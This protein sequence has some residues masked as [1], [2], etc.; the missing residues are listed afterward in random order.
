MP[1]IQ[2]VDSTYG[3]LT[4]LDVVG[5]P[6]GY[7]T[8]DISTGDLWI[9]SNS[10]EEVDHVDVEAVNGNHPQMRWLRDQGSNA[11][12]KTEGLILYAS[13]AGDNASTGADWSTA[14]E[15]GYNAMARIIDAGGGELHLLDSTVWGG[16][17]T[18]Q[19]CWLRDDGLPVEGFQSVVPV[20]IVH[21]GGRHM[22]FGQPAG[23][24][25]GGKTAAGDRFHP[26]F[27][28]CASGRSPVVIENA[29]PAYS[30]H[31]CN[32][33]GRFGWDYR[34]TAA[35]A[36]DFANITEWDRAAGSAVLTVELPAGLAIT[37]AT[38]TSNVTR[39]TFAAQTF[40][41][42][43]VGQWITV[44]SS[45]GSFSSGP[46]QVT[47][48][49]VGSNPTWLEY[50]DVGANAN[51]NNI[52]TW[53]THGVKRY[54]RIE[55][56][57]TDGEVPSCAYRVTDTTALTITVVD[58]YGYAPRTATVTVADPG[59]Y[60]LQDRTNYAVGLLTL[61][62][63]GGA[64]SPSVGTDQFSPGPTMDFGSTTDGRILFEGGSCTGYVPTVPCTDP[65]RA[66]W[67][68]VDPGSHGAAGLRVRHTDPGGTGIRVYGSKVASWAFRA[69]SV[70][71]DTQIGVSAP[72]QLEVLEGGQYGTIYARDVFT[73]DN[74]PAVPNVRLDAAG[75]QITVFDC[76]LVE[77]TGNVS[78]GPWG[79]RNVSP[80]VAG[81]NCFWAG[82]AAADIPHARR[83]GTLLTPRYRNFVQNDSS[84]W[85]LDGGN[86]T[87]AA[88]S[89]PWG[90]NT[91]IRLTRVGGS[92]GVYVFP[93][94]EDTDPHTST[95]FTH[96]VGDRWVAGCYLRRDTGLPGDPLFSFNMA[97]NNGN[98]GGSV[99]AVFT[100]DGEW[101]WY[102]FGG[103]L[104]TITDS[105]SGVRF[106]LQAEFSRSGSS[107]DVCD[108]LLLRVPA[109]DMTDNEFAEWVL[110]L[111]PTDFYLPV[112]MAG[113]R[114]GI[115]VIGHGG[116]GTG[117]AYVEGVASGQLTVAGSFTPKKYEPILKADGT[118]KGWVELVD[119]SV[120]P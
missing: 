16:P 25:V 103:T 109:G 85:D 63:V 88:C 57:S 80:I 96:V 34:R 19:G 75:D 50:A 97:G 24:L 8:A 106:S 1:T 58:T 98:F 71:G 27:W 10:T 116:L 110:A 115:K 41:N 101:Q 2:L 32:Q 42:A 67:M 87:A 70:H 22:Q 14:M 81:Q 18:D 90:G 69:E 5:K 60:V 47:N 52:G 15:N 46:F 45:S 33:V 43:S 53:Q 104:E 54:D 7:S 100:G 82:R 62:N 31:E 84:T 55:V 74:D 3:D 35:G 119:A 29:L 79:S 64:V 51:V 91:A 21:H 117:L 39:L 4:D 78:S 13:P 108:P 73:D 40:I 76:G 86:I 6:I 48:Y 114:P 95:Q 92:D 105:H 112:G 17:V 111:Q 66:C 99:A 72:P 23:R 9:L 93:Q 61:R 26:L 38:R 120:N 28:V 118:V 102:V 107:I 49:Q 65:D 68:L 37:N 89:D 59:T 12:P 83:A 94:D 77:A 30:A 36:I 20:R 11:A 56:V 113:T 44:T